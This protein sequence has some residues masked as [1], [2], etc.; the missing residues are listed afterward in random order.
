VSDPGAAGRPN[1]L[2]IANEGIWGFMAELGYAAQRAAGEL[3]IEARQ[4]HT[5]ADE[6]QVD[7][8]LVIG[9]VRLYPNVLA[10]PHVA[11]RVLWHTEPLPRTGP[12]AGGVGHRRLPTG[13]LLDIARAALPPLESSSTWRQWREQAANVREPLTN[14]ALLRR[15]APAFDRIVIDTRA[16]AEGALRAGIDVAIVPFGYHAAYAGALAPP[17]MKRDIDVLSL[18]NV[19][20]VARRQR[21]M[22]EIEAALGRSGVALTQAERHTYGGSRTQLMRR[23]KVVLDIH[24]VPGSHPLYRFILAAAAGAALVSEPLAQPEPLVPGVHYVEAA[25]SHLGEATLELLADEPRR[26]RIAQAAQALLLG[27]LD[28]RH[29]LPRAL[30]SS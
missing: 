28:L 16:R 14:L 27:E 3:G 17:E 4:V 8:L 25:T 5:G 29:T 22:P 26:R 6:A 7:T 15:N 11:R 30:G 20:R 10:R 13:K 1:R 19:D 2:G 9:Q 18:A 12:E 21:L 23:S 24:R